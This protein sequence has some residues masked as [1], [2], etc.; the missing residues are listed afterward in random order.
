MSNKKKNVNLLDKSRDIN[1][2]LGDLE[3]EDEE[4]RERQYENRIAMLVS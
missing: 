3:K 4:Q 1:E 2:L